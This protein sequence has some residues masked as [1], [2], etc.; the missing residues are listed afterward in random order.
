MEDE[1][2]VKYEGG[3]AVEKYSAEDFEAVISSSFLPRLQLMTAKSQQVAA[4][5]F[6]VNNYALVENSNLIDLG[7]TV[8]CINL[9]WRPKAIRLSGEQVIAVFDPKN[10]L[11]KTIQ[12]EA[13]GPGQGAMAGPE[14]LVYI[15]S[16]KKYATF[17]LGSKSARREAPKTQTFL[18]KAMTL[19]SNKVETKKF[20][21]FTP[22]VT[23]CSTPFDIPDQ[24]E[25]QEQIIKFNNPP[26][27]EIEEAPKEGEEGRERQVKV[28]IIDW[29]S[30]M[31]FYL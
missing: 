31:Y 15:P 23:A 5:E 7:D 8:D 1:Q 28:H 6:P 10:P 25:M 20:T 4:G 19:K 12:E 16:V 30:R 21:W 9:A 17:L 24:E 26:E 22:I 3:A 18:K 2:I 13:D 29:P 11:F 14:Y 27:T